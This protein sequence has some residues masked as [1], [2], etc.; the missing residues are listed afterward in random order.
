MKQRILL[1]GGLAMTKVLA[2]ML[3]DKGSSVAVI[4]AEATEAAALA[5]NGEITVI[6]GDATRPE[7]LDE[8]GASVSDMVFALTSRD[9]VNLLI[10][11][12]CKKNFGVRR[13]AAL[14]SDPA[15]EELFR[16]LGVDGVICLAADAAAMAEAQE[17]N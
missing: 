4:S 7:I 13:T 17:A 8:A 10:C 16:K 3:S 14:I 9:E 11:E 12:L 2:A 15:K 6:C 5:E 1:A